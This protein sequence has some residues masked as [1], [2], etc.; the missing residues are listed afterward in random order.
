[1]TERYAI[2][3]VPPADQPL[4]RMASAWLGRDPESGT[5]SLPDLPP[6]LAHARWREITGDARH[7]GFHGTLKPPMALASGATP[8]G[9]DAALSLFAADVPPLPPLALQ[10]STIGGF[11]A[12]LPREASAA[13]NRLAGL[14][15][16]QFDKF[17]APATAAELA[18]RRRAPLSA[19]QEANLIRWGY[20]YLFDDYRFHMTLTGY[21]PETERGPVE[22]YLSD[23]L[24]PALAHP[25]PLTLALFVQN[26]RQTPF[27]LVR[28]LPLGA[29]S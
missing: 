24:A 25:M 9:L 16:E 21:L 23:L 5:E 28:R 17:R 6:W 29:P 8:D 18:H 19:R 12:L 4:W 2:Y 20:P 10:V 1:M 26:T 22:A 3:A 11:V 13:L 7:Y 15:V 27:R 14:A